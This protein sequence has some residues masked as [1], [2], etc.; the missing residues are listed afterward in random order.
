M[1]GLHGDRTRALVVLD[2]ERKL[3]AVAAVRGDS[4]RPFE[5]KLQPLGTLTGRLVDAEGKPL[6]ERKVLLF[7]WL[8]P[9]KFENLPEEWCRF[10]SLIHTAW[11]D[12]TTR[13]AP[14][15]SQGRFR[16][17]GLLPGQRYDL[18]AGRGRLDRRE[19]LTHR[20][21][22]LRVEPGKVKDA[23]ELKPKL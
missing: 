1:T 2:Q 11:R 10:D 19:A 5:V 20:Y 14:T 15:D 17:D 3:G 16:I 9:K 4:D 8:D 22:D 6:P 12:F 7:L 13:E 23:D 21:R 18:N